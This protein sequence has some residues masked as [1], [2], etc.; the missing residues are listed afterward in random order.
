M[1]AQAET[2]HVVDHAGDGSTTPT[3][4]SLQDRDSEYGSGKPDTSINNTVDVDAARRGITKRIQQLARVKAEENDLLEEDLRELQ[5]LMDKA[6]RWSEKRARLRGRIRD[7]EGAGPDGRAKELQEEATKLEHEI[8]L[9][10]EELMSLKARHRQVL[11]ELADTE[12]TIEA[13]LSSY[14]S[15]LSILD[16]E[17]T[18][19]LKK[20]PGFR[21]VPMSYPFVTL[22][23]NRRTLDMLQEYWQDEHMRLAGRCEKIGKERAALSQGAVLWN[24]V[25]AKVR[26][27]EEFLREQPPD[28]DA[29]IILSRMKSMIAYLTEKLAFATQRNW[30]PLVIAIGAELEAF[31]TGRR[32][33]EEASGLGPK[34]K[35]KASDAKVGDE[36]QDPSLLSGFDGIAHR[37]S[38]FNVPESLHM[39]DEDPDPE[40]LISHE[41][42]DS[43][44]HDDTS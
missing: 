39:H 34:G 23:P 2:E 38:A 9:K 13:E 3:V 8:R 40:L 18:R 22:P 30:N 43:E 1:N 12:N 20:P 25:V 10:E 26:E 21:H 36:A 5:G 19:L 15:A 14:K 42:E 16:K 4:S 27:F 24:E 29:S 44:H 11:T 17:V 35:E 7:V 6:A 32:W 37:P 28:T 33:L 31:R 41:D